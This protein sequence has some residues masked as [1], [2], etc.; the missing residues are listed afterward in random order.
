MRRASN[1]P[2]KCIRQRAP[3]LLSL[4]VGVMLCLTMARAEPVCPGQWSRLV[5]YAGSYDADRLLH[6]PAVAAALTA[7]LGSELPH[8]RRNLD[9]RGA[10]DLRSCELV[11]AGNAPHAGG[12]E[13]AILS[14]NLYRGT[15]AAAILSGGQITIYRESGDYASLPIGIKDWVAVAAAGFEYRLKPPPNAVLAPSQGTRL[16]QKR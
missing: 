9:V 10:V 7:L 13:N 16:L 1:D 3:V 15:L 6:D 2:G 11:I 12:E 14:I 8:L 4:A 5:V